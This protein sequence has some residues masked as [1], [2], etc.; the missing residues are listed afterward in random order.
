MVRER[1]SRRQRLIEVGMDLFCEHTYEEISIDDIAEAADISKGL[2]YYYFPTKHD[3]YVAVVQSAAEQLLHAIEDAS[4]E[5]LEPLERLRAGLNAYFAYAESHAQAYVTLMRSGVGADA[6]VV[7]II[8][9]TRQILVQRVLENAARIT[10]LTP[11]HHIAISGWIGFVEAAC[12]A[13]LEQHNI[14]REQLGDLAM[15]AFTTLW[16]NISG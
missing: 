3:F 5:Q 13:W 4:T 16:G 8:D 10:P 12:I 14:E 6:R 2:L 9:A 15:T 11:L 7:A 1:V